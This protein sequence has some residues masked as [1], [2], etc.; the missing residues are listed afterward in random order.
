MFCP[1]NG[2]F[3]IG[4]TTDAVHIDG[5]LKGQNIVAFDVRIASLEANSLIDL[6]PQQNSLLAIHT[7]KLQY[8]DWLLDEITLKG[9]GLTESHALEL[10]ATGKELLVTARLDGQLRDKSW[11]GSINQLAINTPHTGEWKLGRSS[12]ITWQGKT[13]RFN[14]SNTCLE[15]IDASLCLSAS[16][17]VQKD[18]KTTIRVD[19]FPMAMAQA[20]LPETV[21]LNGAVSG[22]ISLNRLDEH[23]ELQTSLEGNGTQVSLGFEE[24]RE[25]LD[26]PQVSLAAEATPGKRAW[27]LQLRSPEYFDIR[28]DGSVQ[29]A[30]NR[31]I[32]ADIKV[33][34][35]RIDWLGGVEPALSGSKGRFEAS[36]QASGTVDQPQ[37]QGEFSLIDGHLSFIP[38]GLTLD[39]VTGKLESGRERSQMLISSILGN[40]GRQLEVKGHVILDAG[41]DYP[42]QLQLRGE[43]FPLV[44]TVD[45]T[46]D[47]SPDLDLHGSLKL[48]HVRGNVA[49]PLLDMQVTSLPEDS[50]SVSPDTVVML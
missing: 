7:G 50:V 48:H 14:V 15:Q 2:R 30:G 5:Q 34:L 31:P 20:W 35:Y 47:A 25:T 27:K 23:W 18:V 13:N 29:N 43:K 28:L 10:M 21:S 19:R 1:L 12:E 17:D 33:D 6:G 38:A 24:D 36:M 39:R 22:D 11:K 26:V 46:M 41:Q 45:I 40:D 3:D 9:K 49:I 32:S 4:G 8:K 16:G 37:I 44:R 42:Y